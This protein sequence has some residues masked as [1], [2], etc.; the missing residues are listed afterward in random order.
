MIARVGSLAI[1]YLVGIAVS[2][3]LG[4]VQNGIL[5]YPLAFVSFFVAMAA[6]GL[7]GFLTREL[8]IKPQK[9][10]TLIGTAFWMRFAAGI[11]ILPLIFITYFLIT[12]FNEINTPLNYIVVVGFTGFLQSFNIIDSYFQSRTQGKYIMYVQVSGNL[13]SASIKL[14]LIYLQAPLSWFV[15]SLAIDALILAAGY[16]MVYQSK[17]NSVLNWKFDSR[18]GKNL[19]KY[20]WPLA[21]SALL[22]SLYMKI[23]QLM[24]D[25]YI[26]SG[27]L[28]IYSTV[29]SLSE[30]WYFIPVAIVTSVF[31][32]IMNAKNNDRKR[33]LK[34]L[35]N[36]YD[37]MVVISVSIAIIMTFASG[38]VYRF[39]YDAEY[40]PGASVLSVHIWAGIFVFLGTASSQYLIAEGYTKIA[41]LRTGAGAIVNIVLNIIWIPRFGITG[42]AYATLIAYF[43]STFLIILIPRTRNQGLMMLKSLFLVSLMQ[44]LI[45]R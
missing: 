2:N 13:L 1:K 3:Y 40:W 8:L 44:K 41:M 20:S 42:A 37:L 18:L 34:R 27:E 28:G 4:K 11:L 19:L 9:K 35:Q 36:M 32:A 33:Y 5:N 26:G 15:Y 38:F 10:D 23:D 25:Y 43:A 17:G 30:S 12:R 22:V 21:L 6:L 7:D 31:P 45:Q 16:I 29:V 39:F 14:A 24:I